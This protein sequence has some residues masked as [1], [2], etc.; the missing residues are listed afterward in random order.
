MAVISSNAK[1]A[2]CRRHHRFWGLPKCCPDG[3]CR[4][5]HRKQTRRMSLSEFDWADDPHLTDIRAIEQQYHSLA[6]AMQRGSAR[7]DA[8]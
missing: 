6:T 4:I 1:M 2:G 5:E 8:S 7:V 3:D